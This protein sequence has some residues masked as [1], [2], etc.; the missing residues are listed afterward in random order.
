MR[1]RRPRS[2]RM[3]VRGFPILVTALL[4]LGLASNTAL[5]QHVQPRVE[6]LDNGLKILLVERHEQPTV[7]LG[8]FFDVGSVDDP[9][10]RS[11]IAH[12]FEHMMFKG[13]RVIGT[14]DYATERVLIAQQDQVRAKMAAEMNRM[15]LMK[16]RG[17]ITD[18]LDPDQWTPEYTE[19]KKRYDELLATQRA[20]LK[21]N[22]LDQ[23]YGSNGGA[24]MNAGT[25]EDAT[26]Y[27]VRLPSNKIELFFWLES[28]RMHNGIMRE[29][30]VERENVREERRLR[31]ESTP[32][33]KFDEAFEAL[34][35]Q[36]HPYGIP[37]L[38]W[39]SEVESITRDD[40]RDFYRE[41]Y[42]PNRATL[43]VVGDFDSDQVMELAKRY[44]G[45]IPP[46]KFQRPLVVTEEPKPIAERR[47][48]AE[49]ETNPRV[50]IRYHTVA[51]G[52][53]D[54]AALDV[55]GQLLSRKTGRLYKRLVTAEDAAIG[56]PRAAHSSRK[57]A[58]YFEISAVVKEDHT[59]EQVERL[60]LEEIDQLREGEITDYELQKVKNQVLASSVRRL[61]S[62]LG[63]MFQLGIYQTWL[64]WSYIND[65]PQRMLAIT[66]DQ[67]RRVVN[68]YFDPK[69][70]TVAIYRTKGGTASEVDAELEAVL[71]NVPPEAHEQIKG[72]IKQVQQSDDLSRL[73]GMTQMMEQG[74]AGGQVP[75]E[76]RAL[77]EYMLEVIKAR[78]AELEAAGNETA[79]QTAEADSEESK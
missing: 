10:G 11:G 41:Y 44:F 7:S 46:S 36:S 26:I 12:M 62:G 17:Q 49:A 57:Y 27:F 40:V 53:T 34:F 29:F 18:V 35:W 54:E 25:M 31:T 61:K 43:V 76:Q 2:S 37:V 65:A 15:R 23:L 70:R 45:P 32:T 68:E 21:N 55:L 71:A 38:G 79:E 24:S 20:K 56:Q 69:T 66:A 14:T 50:R 48:F 5:A 42:A 8:L 74:L 28:D 72:M 59:P 33:G 16:R 64:D 30:Y 78:V 67:V 22:E 47:F 75:E 52:H 63:L 4:L 60:I 77:S 13:T 1:I 51:L 58:G 9:R 73:S 6:E 3:L 39:A 19:L